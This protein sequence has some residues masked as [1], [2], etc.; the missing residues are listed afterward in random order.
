MRSRLFL[1]HIVIINLFMGFIGYEEH[2]SSPGSKNITEISYRDISFYID[3]G[4]EKLF[5]VSI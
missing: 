4:S 2:F 1:A 3:G 5:T